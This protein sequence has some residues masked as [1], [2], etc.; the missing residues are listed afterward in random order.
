M[1]SMGQ[2]AAPLARDRGRAID[3]LARF[4]ASSIDAAPYDETPFHHLRL[5]HVFPDDIYAAMLAAMPL[6][7]DY[8]PMSGRA[9]AKDLADGVQTRV[10]IDLFPEYIRGLPAPKRQ[11]WTLVGAA[12]C[13]AAV[14]DAFRRRLARGLATRFGSAASDVGLYPVPVLTRDFP[15]YRIGPHPD[16][17]W[18]G[19]TVQLYLPHD[20]SIAH[21][22][23]AFLEPMPDGGF[24]TREQMPFVPNSGYAFVVDKDTWHSAGPIGPEVTSRDSILLTYFIDRGA[25]R[26]LRNRGKRIGNFVLNEWRRRRE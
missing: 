25:L 11:V 8:R 3:H 10:K 18:K 1:V 23:T 12:L 7:A 2:T 20:A 22:G 15:G 26:R 17:H 16:T 24:A 4:I 6:P 14:R 5:E 13:S 21:V 19:I 9:G